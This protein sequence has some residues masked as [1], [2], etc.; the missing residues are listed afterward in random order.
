VLSYSKATK[1]RS[2]FNGDETVKSFRIP[3]SKLPGIDE[4]IRECINRGK[5]LL[6]RSDSAGL[7]DKSPYF[8]KA[9]SELFKLDNSGNIIEKMDDRDMHLDLDEVFYFSDIPQP[10]SLSNRNHIFI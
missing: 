10:E 2:S 5:W 8:L 7:S 4:S 6:F 9:G 3:S 1:I